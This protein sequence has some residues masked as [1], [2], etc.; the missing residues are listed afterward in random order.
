MTNL[1]TVKATK[2]FA[3]FSKNRRSTI[4]KKS[5]ITFRI[6]S[7]TKSLLKLPKRASLN[8]I[9]KRTSTTIKKPT[10]MKKKFVD[11]AMQTPKDFTENAQNEDKESWM[12]NEEKNKRTTKSLNKTKEALRQANYFDV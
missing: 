5:K 12:A 9:T 8:S 1:A 7:L 10:E 4:K 11:T 2:D 6:S 3:N